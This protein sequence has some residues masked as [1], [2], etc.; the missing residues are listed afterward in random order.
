MTEAQYIRLQ[1]VL[2]L[3]THSPAEAM[4]IALRLNALPL[5]F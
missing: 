4:Q 1:Y 3:R 5:P 2:A